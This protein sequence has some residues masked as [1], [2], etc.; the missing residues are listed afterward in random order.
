M[1]RFPDGNQSNRQMG[2]AHAR[3][4]EKHPRTPLGRR[5]ILQ[6]RIDGGKSQ[7]VLRTGNEVA[8]HE[9]RTAPRSVT[10]IEIHC[11]PRN[12][13][14]NDAVYHQ[15][16]NPVKQRLMSQVS[17]LANLPALC[18]VGTRISSQLFRRCKTFYSRR[19]CR[20]S[21]ARKPGLPKGSD[22]FRNATTTASLISTT[23]AFALNLKR[24]DEATIGP[25]TGTAKRAGQ[26]SVDPMVAIRRT[27]KRRDTVGYLFS[28]E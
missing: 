28:F 9:R 14:A 5:P 24:R 3:W 16:L 23:V 2:L 8:E 22:D 11:I 13:D 7:M 1:P 21:E 12:G 26:H 10:R 4:S 6:D 19:L 27:A 17:I 20:T 25:G 15:R 18:E